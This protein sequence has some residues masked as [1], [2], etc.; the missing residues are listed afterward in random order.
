M[1]DPVPSSAIYDATTGGRSVIVITGGSTGQV[2]TLQSD[3]TYAPATPSAGGV[4]TLGTTGTDLNISGSTLNVP[5]AGSASRGVIAASGAQTLGII[6]TI[7][8]GTVTTS[9][10]MT[11]TQT[12]NAGAVTFNALLLN[13]T[14]TASAAASTLLDLQVAGSSKFRVSKAGRV[15]IPEY[16]VESL[17]GEILVGADS[18]GYYMLCGLTSDSSPVFLGAKG[19]GTHTYIG[20]TNGTVY[21]RGKALRFGV[22][23]TVGA[24][25][26]LCTVSNSTL[27]L[28]DGETPQCL[29]VTNT[30][31]S[32]TV[33]ECL[34]FAATAT[35]N[36]IS[37]RIGSAGGSNRPINIGHRNSAGAFTS[38][39]SIGI[40]GEATFVSSIAAGTTICA[41]TYTVATLPSAA[42]NAYKFATVSDSSVTTF[43]STV[44]G[45][46][47]SKV[48][49]YSNGTNWTVCA[50]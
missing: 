44:A 17:N 25:Q 9:Q 19:D 41:G 8:M 47:S 16:L 6:P 29:Q 2:L 42:A 26:T 49:V 35:A 43:G 5:N 31:T 40:T 50:A 39:L 45:G 33:L 27:V 10:P 4:T 22:N 28:R 32:S 13:V 11:V 46:G 48:M 24:G 12:W 18:S 21:L 20:G 1:S 15:T 38:A 37:S 3:G 7:A 36:E 23:S 14:N 34:D 30:Y